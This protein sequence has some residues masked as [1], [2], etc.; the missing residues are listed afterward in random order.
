MRINLSAHGF[1][2][3][4][5]WVVNLQRRFAEEHDMRYGSVL[6]SYMASPGGVKSFAAWLSS[7]GFK[8]KYWCIEPL[9]SYDALGRK[10][11]EQIGFGL[12]FDDKCPLLTEARLKA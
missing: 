12:D 11:V 3:K 8:A 1:S 5:Q 9:V 2:R 10:Q 4:K 7:N 6:Q